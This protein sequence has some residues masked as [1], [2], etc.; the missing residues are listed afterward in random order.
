MVTNLA[1]NGP[2]SLRQAITDANTRPGSD[3]I[4]FAH[5]ARGT[6]VLS[7]QLII[8]DDLTILGPG[9]GAV[10]VSGGGTSRVFSVL[11]AELAATP[12]VSPTLAQLETAPTVT[13]AGLTIADGLGTDAPGYHPSNGFGWAG[14]L[15]NLGGTIHLNQVAMIGNLA[16]GGL[17]AGGAIANEFG[18]TITIARSH[19]QG[20]EASGF[21]IGVGGAIT[22]DTGATVDGT[23]GPP[24]LTIHQTTFID[25]AA[26]SL[27]GYVEGIPFSGLSLGGAVLNVTGCL[28]IDRSHFEGNTV[29][30]GPGTENASAGGSA[31]GGAVYS[32][33]VGPFGVSDS[34]TTVRRSVFV[35]NTA[36]GGG[37]GAAGLPGGEAAGGAVSVNNGGDLLLQHNTFRGNAA[38]GGTGGLDAKGG[39]A[40]G[41]AVAGAGGAS[42]TLER[43]AF[44]DNQVQGG[45][46]FGAGSSAPSQGAGLALHAVEITGLVPG[47]A[48]ASVNRDTFFQ[49]TA[50]G[51]LGGGIF[52]NGNLNVVHARFQGNRAVGNPDVV[53]D[54]GPAFKVAGGAGGGG[55]AN[56]GTLQVS[57]GLF[58]DN[59]VQGAD[60]VATLPNAFPLG[61]AFPGST[62]GGAIANFSTSFG[63]ASASISR[64]HFTGNISRA[65]NFGN[66]E[67]AAIGG[68]GAIFNSASMTVAD[69]AFTSNRAIAGDNAVSPFH[70]GHALGGA[71]NSGSLTP[72]V[73]PTDPGASLT[74]HRSRF[75]SNEAI[76][77]NHNEVTLPLD[78]VPLAD[79]PN[80]AYGGAVLVYQGIGTITQSSL[81]HN[82]AIAGVGGAEQKGSLGVGGGVFFFGFLGP[83]S[84][85]IDRSTIAHNAAIGGNG[86]EGDGGHGLGGGIAIGTLGSPFSPSSEVVLTRNHLLG[87]RAL[88]GQ[89]TP[90]FGNGGDG[91]GGG[92]GVFNGGSAT[93]EHSQLLLNRAVGGSGLIGGNGL[94]GGIFNDAIAS[95]TLLRSMIFLNAAFGN[96]AG[97]GLGGG[98]FNDAGGLF[99]I[100]PPSRFMT[101][102]NLAS[103]DGD[104]VFGDLTD[105]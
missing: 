25:N 89:G 57:G 99:Q 77:G 47:T 49:N 79:A 52:N 101:R 5:E 22:S 30:S 37:G 29:E 94:G 73:D 43:N 104:D 24:T 88:G 81:L 53:L 82:R 14:G 65:G 58:A 86:V 45:S 44:R 97:T 64:T 6:I 7:E 31:F 19:F 21:G 26:R 78:Q 12:L 84:G 102:L 90:G 2:G 17:A 36:T 9:A 35:E 51:G 16:V 71:I 42:L 63:S 11:P 95:T 103:D 54:L 92:I 70:N 13:I 41:G 46:G 50:I 40:S 100:D 98:I 59:Q 39:T 33:D 32:G 105:L 28:T 87:N 18:G 83:V 62:N 74:I 8:T 3:L 48:I 66:G 67:F 93:I 76:G 85:S 60:N 96:G 55:I 4:Q 15:Y 91:L 75:S 38:L 20:N 1:E 80:N 68:G 34:T 23:S 10:T 72:A 27:T 56:V 69:S 61:P